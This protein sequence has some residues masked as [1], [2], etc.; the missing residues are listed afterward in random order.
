MK[1]L[2]QITEAKEETMNRAY[3]I[4]KQREEAE[5]RAAQIEV[6]TLYWLGIVAC[7]FVSVCIIA[8]YIVARG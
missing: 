8:G 3:Q 7:G 6:E 2:T 1:N 4:R 5:K